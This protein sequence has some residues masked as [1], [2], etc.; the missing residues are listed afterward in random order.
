MCA[1]WKKK[2][3]EYDRGL[4]V[5][6]LESLRT[7]DASGQVG[8]SAWEF[9]DYVSVLQSSIDFSTK[10]PE[11]ERRRIVRVALRSLVQTGKLTAEKVIA[12]I[13][14]GEN[15]FIE[16]L[17]RRFILATSLSIRHFKSLGSRQIH[18][19]R[20]TF[21]PFLPR[22]FD[23]SSLLR[24]A[25][26]QGVSEPPREYTQV[27][28]S[29]KARSE[30]EA[31]NLALDAFDL[32][33]GIWNI[34]LNYTLTGRMS[35]GVLS[36]KMEPVNQILPGPLHTLHLPSGT[37][38]TETYWYEPSVLNQQRFT[39]IDLK[40]K[41]N[42]ILK[43]E[44]DTRRALTSIAYKANL[45]D[46]LRAY[47]RALDLSDFNAAFL[48]LW[49]VL[50]KLTLCEGD[51]RAARRRVLFLINAQERTFHEQILRHLKDYRNRAVH[52][53][54]ETEE[55]ETLV[56]Q[57]KSYVERL[58]FFHLHNNMGFSNMKETMEFLDL[59]PGTPTLKKKMK[60]IK[61]AIRYH[62]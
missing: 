24:R 29:L 46:A 55:I 1:T 54:E 8:F 15:S 7:T 21:S 30:F 51:Y 42:R 48:A 26:R 31:A 50:E 44:N 34:A 23:R 19:V 35:G 32:V 28:I 62:K 16:S 39:A 6:G 25:L 52:A 3:E 47:T 49:R 4:L 58:L 12:E 43:V 18:G 59:P 37:L 11:S 14:K 13:S 17:P 60:M 56:F 5:D 36:G 45:E 27:R 2:P 38:A 40:S 33:R 20:I 61:G 22:R 9:L 57:L 53:G 41:W 10:L